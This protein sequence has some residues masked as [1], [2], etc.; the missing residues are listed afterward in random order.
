MLHGLR[1]V[2][3]GRGNQPHVDGLFLLS[4][5]APDRAFLQH[6]QQLGLNARRDLG[7]LVEEQR[8]G[9]RQLEAARAPIDRAG[10]RAALVAEDFVLEQRFRNRRAVDRDERMLASPAELMDRLGDELLAGAG[11]S[12]HEHRRGR[13]RG[14]LDD[15]IDRAQGRRV[16]DHLA[17]T[18]V[19][20]QLAAQARDVAQR[21]LALGDVRQ[22]R[23]EP[24]RIDRLRQVVV[25]AFLHRRHGGVDAALGG[26]QHE[27]EVGKLLLD[28]A[29]QL[30]AVHP[31]HH[32]V[33]EHRRRPIRGDF[34]EPFLAVGGAFGLVP[35]GAHQLGQPAA[36][37]GVIFDNKHTHELS[38]YNG[39]G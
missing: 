26:N 33:G 38:G 17:E 27:R 3:V 22:Q 8:A 2:D 4:A 25:R 11:L 5:E 10:E 19:V 7:D 15:A 32:H 28:A 13:R 21:V 31:R 29:K 18:A 36:G 6:A 14:L 35:P 34:L 37:R 16:A 24:L 30:E 12:I 9:V 23:T 39:K 1:R 20:L